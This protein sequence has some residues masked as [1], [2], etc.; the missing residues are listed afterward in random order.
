MAHTN[1]VIHSQLINTRHQVLLVPNTAIAEIVYYTTPEPMDN[2][3]TPEWLL[4]AIKWRGLNVP[5]VSYESATGG[6]LGDVDTTQRIAVING[7]HSDT[8]LQFYAIVIQGNPRL[9]NVAPE[10]I[11]SHTGGEIYKFQLQHVIVNNIVAVIPDL[12]ALE[13]MITQEGLRSEGVH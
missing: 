6:E 7:V 2:T 10:N 13:Q 8:A 11:N 4:G 9:I 5:V 3:N 12:R 1:A